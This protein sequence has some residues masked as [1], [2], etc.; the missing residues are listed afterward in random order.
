MEALFAADYGFCGGVLRG[1][2]LLQE[3][4]EIPDSLYGTDALDSSADISVL[5]TMMAREG[6]TGEQLQAEKSS[7]DE[8]NIKLEL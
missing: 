2:Y 8:T 5:E 3:R 6:L 7:A 1:E 4:E